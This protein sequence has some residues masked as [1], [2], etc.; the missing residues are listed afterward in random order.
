MTISDT[1]TAQEYQFYIEF[2]STLTL[3]QIKTLDILLGMAFLNGQ[4]KE[5]DR[6]IEFIKQAFE[7]E[8]ELS[9]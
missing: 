5:L 7:K 8:I 1:L 6:S 2:C 4:N 9:S 3:T